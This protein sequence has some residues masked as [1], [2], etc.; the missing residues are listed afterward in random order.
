MKNAAYEKLLITLVL[1]F[2]LCAVNVNA[3]QKPVVNS[4]AGT[5]VVFGI[6]VDNSGSTRNI[7]ET[8]IQTTKKF[9]KAKQSSDEAFLVRFISS[10][11]INVMVAATRDED[12]LTA[13]AEEMYPEGG[14]SAITDA[15]YIAAKE[16]KLKN[17]EQ[18]NCKQA[19]ILISDGEERQ[20]KFKP[21]ELLDALKEKNIRVYAISLIENLN[22][23]KEVK[24]LQNVTN[25]TGGK[26]YYPKN[27][28]EI[29]TSVTE[30]L[31]S[32][33]Q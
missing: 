1:F 10:D 32:V 24:F 30:I 11:K 16:I 9:A 17:C 29:D 25:Q 27:L 12:E 8:I 21:Q 15:L 28:E 18:I 26:A 13:G 19:L 33:R 6:V 22:R 7:L 23:N 2:S 4:P 5:S 14:L 20:S 31:R 3:Q